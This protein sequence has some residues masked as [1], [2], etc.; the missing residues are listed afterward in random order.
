MYFH[1]NPRIMQFYFTLGRSPSRSS[2]SK[3]SK[4]LGQSSNELGLRMKGNE[5]ESVF[6]FLQLSASSLLDSVD[7]FLQSTKFKLMDESGLKLLFPSFSRSNGGEEETKV[8]LF[9]FSTELPIL[10]VEKTL[11]GKE[12]DERTAAWEVGLGFKLGLYT[13]VQTWDGYSIPKDLHGFF[14][15]WFW[16]R[17]S[18][19]GIGDC[20]SLALSLLW[21]FIWPPRAWADLNSL[22]QKLQE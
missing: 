18:S 14:S 13:K 21:T 7:R 20:L 8:D 22:L 6:L 1:R 19:W 10:L 3:S 5:D 15:I 9:R 11:E 12:C 2:R 16:L 17:L 4:E